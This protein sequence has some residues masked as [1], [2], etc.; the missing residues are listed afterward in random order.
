MQ[1]GTAKIAAIHD[2]DAQVVQR[3]PARIH[4]HGGSAERDDL[5]CRMPASHRLPPIDSRHEP[6]WPDIG[7]GREFNE[8][9]GARE[10][11]EIAGTV[12]RF[13]HRPRPAPVVVVHRNRQEGRERRLE[14]HRLGDRDALAC[15]VRAIPSPG[16]APAGHNAP[17]RPASRPDC[18]GSANTAWPASATPNHIGFPGAGRCDETPAVRRVLRV[19][20]ARD[21]SGPS[22]RR[23]SGPARRA[24]AGEAQAL[25]AALPCRPADDRPRRVAKPRWR[26][27]AATP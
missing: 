18:P 17:G 21:R 12:G 6:F 11:A 10:R 24:C 13:R 7:P 8:S 22:T 14:F 23:R 27:A 16:R 19:P 5:Q 26:N 15:A 1:Y 20:S 3:A 9:V 4:W 25:A 2:R